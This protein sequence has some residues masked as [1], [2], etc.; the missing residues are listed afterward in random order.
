MSE[1]ALPRD[2]EGREIPLDTETM[3]SADGTACEV[4]EWVYIY[5]R[6]GVPFWHAKGDG[7]LIC[8]NRM[9]LVPPDS[10]EKLLEDLDRTA[11]SPRDYDAE[12]SYFGKGLGYGNCKECPAGK[13][14]SCTAVMLEDVA[15]RIR[16]LRGDGE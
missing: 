11:A 13:H 12:C 5:G 16:K 1:V 7:C 9:H 10:W 15:A 6:N 14:A 3:Y 2:C 4:H 8:P